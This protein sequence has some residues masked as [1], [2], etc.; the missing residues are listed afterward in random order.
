MSTTELP[1]NLA[2]P[3]HFN[4]PPIHDLLAI[5]LNNIIIVMHSAHDYS[6]TPHNGHSEIWTASVQHT[7][8]V[9]PIDSA[10]ETIHF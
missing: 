2:T 8:N 7:G 5:H 1:C 6:G 3:I 4:L 9:P 10:I